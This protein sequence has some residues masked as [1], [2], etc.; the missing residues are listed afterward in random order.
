MT[1]KI[2][3]ALE[4]AVRH[5]QE[6]D[7]PEWFGEA[8]MALTSTPS[9]DGWRLEQSIFAEMPY[10]DHDLQGDMIL[11]CGWKGCSRPHTLLLPHQLYPEDAR[12]IMDHYG[13]DEV[14]IFGLSTAN[15]LTI[16]RAELDA[17]CK[18]QGE[19]T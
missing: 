10:I 3:E 18:A 19:P 15:E 17:A 4:K 2:R 13:H 6:G 5:A 16:T 8:C 11:V 7:R 9:P 1:D 14:R 12:K